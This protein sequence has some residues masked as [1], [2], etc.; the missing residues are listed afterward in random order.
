LDQ[1]YGK[2]NIQWVRLIW[3]RYYSNAVPHLA[4]EKGSFWW[5]DLLRLHVQYRGVAL[6][7]TG[8][9]DT[10]GFWEDF[11]DGKFHSEVYP[12]LFGY[13]KDPKASLSVMM[14]SKDLLDCFRIP[15]SRRAYNE[16]LELQIELTNLASSLSDE[17]DKWTFIWG[18]QNYSSSRFYQYHFRAIQPHISVLWVC[19]TKCLQ[20]IKVFG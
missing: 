16:F 17:N 19:K 1:F 6:C 2:E 18:N 11:I 3:N 13:A 7:V 20:K 9:G 4:R 10:I 15:M 14:A 8:R 5:K 12:T